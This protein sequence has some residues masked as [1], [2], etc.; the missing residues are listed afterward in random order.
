MM[1]GKP[2]LP[3]DLLFGQAEGIYTVVGDLNQKDHP[4]DTRELR[5]GSGGKPPQFIELNRCHQDQ[6]MA[7]LFRCHLKHQQSFIGNGERYLAHDFLLQKAKGS[8]DHST[9]LPSV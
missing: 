6:I 1:S 9:P 8:S 5:R 3:L 2:C 4:W 7:E